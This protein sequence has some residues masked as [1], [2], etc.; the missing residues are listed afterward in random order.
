MRTET[1]SLSHDVE[2]SMVVL[3]SACHT[4]VGTST[5]AAPVP[6]QSGDGAGRC[7]GFRS[8]L[9][10]HAKRRILG[11]NSARLY[12]L[13]VDGVSH[14]GPYNPVPRDYESRIPDDL[15]QILEFPGFVAQDDNLSRFRKEY[16]AMGCEPSHTRYGWIRTAG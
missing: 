9:T 4:N 7:V 13:P 11:L 10:D 1:R 5:G 3:H 16:L 12:R 8:K 15:K 2:G 14:H 6:R